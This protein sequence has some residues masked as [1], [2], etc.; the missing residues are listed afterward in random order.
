MPS[1]V[2]VDDKIWNH[3]STPDLNEKKLN[4]LD[5]NNKITEI[6]LSKVLQV[7]VCVFLKV[8]EGDIA[9]ISYGEKIDEDLDWKEI[10]EEVKETHETMKE[11]AEEERKNALGE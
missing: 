7:S 11:W 2:Q 3:I 6:T 8:G 9:F 4:Y 5:E 1:V 10:Y